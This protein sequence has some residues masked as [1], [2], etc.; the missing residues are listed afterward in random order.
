MESGGMS[1]LK[2]SVK[3]LLNCG[4]ICE[5]EVV[6]LYSVIAEQ[7]AAALCPVK[8]VA[9]NSAPWTPNP[10]S[11]PESRIPVSAIDS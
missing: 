10:P 3:A 9:R 2:R 11:R 6:F 4:M 1:A 5:E 8:P 7:E